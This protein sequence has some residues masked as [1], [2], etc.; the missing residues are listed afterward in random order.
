MLLLVVLARLD[1]RVDL[2][3][4]VEAEADVLQSARLVPVDELGPDEAIV[5]VWI[6]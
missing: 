2:A 5:R 3:E 6:G 4:S 1:D